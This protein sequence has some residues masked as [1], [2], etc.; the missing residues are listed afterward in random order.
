M[1]LTSAGDY[2]VDFFRKNGYLLR[3]ELR[4]VSRGH[5]CYELFKKV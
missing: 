1:V 2:N 5:S 3:G 4:D